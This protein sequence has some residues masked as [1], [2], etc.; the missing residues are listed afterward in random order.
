M[1]DSAA[2]LTL[3]PIG[4]VRTPF[5]DK[6]SAPRQAALARG[7][8]GT[9]ELLPGPEYEHALQDIERWSHLWVL[10][11]FH[12]SEGFRPTVLPPRSARKRGVFATRAPYRPNPIGMSLVRLLRVE[13]NV[14]HVADLDILD[15]TPVLDIKPY[16]PYADTAPDA[17][18]GWLEDDPGAPKDP[19]PRYAISFSPRAEEQLAFLAERS[20]LPLRSMAEAVLSAGA[21]PHPYR[22]IK[23]LDGQLQLAVKDFRLRFTVEGTRVVVHEVRSGYRPRVLA[24]PEAQATE[25]TPLEVHRAFVA[26][27]GG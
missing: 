6:Q 12:Q 2:H 9:I 22:R 15:G 8:T 14:L 19:G 26:R 4:V 16:V 5:Q 7:V 11:W 27:F 13:R 18:S 17:N 21:A 25:A 3:T 20:P 1:T 24:D 10:F 23:Q